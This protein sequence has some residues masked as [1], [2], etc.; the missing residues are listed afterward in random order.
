MIQASLSST[1]LPQA[2][3][4][5]QQEECEPSHGVEPILLSSQARE[6]LRLLNRVLESSPL[7]IASAKTSVK[8]PP[9]V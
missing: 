9:L 4:Q 8:N 1:M 3:T 7:S 2:M 6:R 5:T